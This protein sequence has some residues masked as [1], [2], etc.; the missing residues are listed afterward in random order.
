MLRL[1]EGLP[2]R[3]GIA[4]PDRDLWEEVWQWR[5]TDDADYAGELAGTIEKRVRKWLEQPE[6]TRSS[7]WDRDGRLEKLS[8]AMSDAALQRAATRRPMKPDDEHLMLVPVA[9]LRPEGMGPHAREVNEDSADGTAHLDTPVLLSTHHVAVGERALQIATA[10]GLPDP[11]VGVVVDAARWH[12]LGKVD[13]RFQAML[14]DGDAILASLAEEPRAKSGMPAGDLRRH[15]DARVRS[16]LP[17]GARHEAWSAVLVA[18]Y[19]DTRESPY[20][21]DADLLVH[22]VASHHGQARPLLPAVED[23]AGHTLTAEV[24]GRRVTADLP[25]GLDLTAAER[26][27]ALNR[28]YGRW[29]L[30]ML[31][32]IVRCA[33]MTVS[34][35]GS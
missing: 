25:H 29:G 8:T 17:E 22:L 5:V 30:A 20:D 31:E 27:E 23:K 3:L 13:P 12:D 11:L 14:F 10:L 15:R 1:D 24:D 19:L 32:A 9:L 26:F 21:G 2:E 35:E 18:D 7:P 33:D 34:G 28:R 6:W 4:P 16:G